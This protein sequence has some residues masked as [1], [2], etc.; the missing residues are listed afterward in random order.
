MEESDPYVHRSQ[1]VISKRPSHRRDL[2][3]LVFVVFLVSSATHAYIHS[4]AFRLGDEVC[5]CSTVLRSRTC[6]VKRVSGSPRMLG[7]ETVCSSWAEFAEPLNIRAVRGQSGTTR[8]F[9]PFSVQL[10][11][12]F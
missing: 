3:V 10:E 1:S 2:L 7:N 11:L 6:I 9:R 5:A 8:S 12:A 4:F